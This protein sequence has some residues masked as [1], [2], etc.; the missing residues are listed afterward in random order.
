MKEVEIKVYE[1]T[2]YNENF[3]IIVY[4][5]FAVKD[6]DLNTF[7]SHQ[8]ACVCLGF[9]PTPKVEIVPAWT[10]PSNIDFVE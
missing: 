8:P 3:G 6:F 5:P 4:K 7:L 2:V 9:N 10:I 1:V